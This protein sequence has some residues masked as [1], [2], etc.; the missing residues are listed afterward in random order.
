MYPP[1]LVEKSETIIFYIFFLLFSALA[2]LEPPPGGVP[3]Q[4][5]TVLFLLFGGL[6]VYSIAQRFLLARDI[7][8]KKIAVIEDEESEL[9]NLEP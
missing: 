1:A 7:F 2:P 4:W 3:F 9:E 5:L 6:I 8:A